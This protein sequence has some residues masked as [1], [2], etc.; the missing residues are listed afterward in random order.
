MINNL[1]ISTVS[2]AD[3][4]N[5]ALTD[6]S[7][8]QNLY[9]TAPEK[10][11]AVISHALAKEKGYSKSGSVLGLLTS[12]TNNIVSIKELQG[13]NYEWD[14][15][16]PTSRIRP[17]TERVDN[18]ER[19]GIAKSI[20]SLAFGDRCFS[21][22]D[23]I[24]ASTG[25]LLYVMREMQP[26]GT[27]WIAYCTLLTD[28]MTDYLPISCVEAG[29]PYSKEYSLVPELSERGGSFG[30]GGKATL[31]NGISR[32]RMSYTMS[33]DALN[34]NI[35]ISFTDDKGKQFK[36]WDKMLQFKALME[37]KRQE[38]YL[39][40]YG[41]YI[42]K[43]KQII[44]K[45]GRPISSGAG[46]R[47][48][49]APSNVMEHNGRI[50]YEALDSY[51]WELSKFGGSVGGDA[52]FVCL[53][54]RGFKKMLDEAIAKKYNNMIPNGL[55]VDKA[56]IITGSGRTMTFEGM[57]FDTIKFDCGITVSFKYFPL[58]DDMSTAR[59]FLTEPST[60]L[61]YDSF[62]AT[63]FNI[64][65]QSTIKRFYQKDA[66][67]CI[68][69]VEGSIDSTGKTSKSESNGKAT[70]LDGVE[71]HHLGTAGIA[72]LDP[73]SAGEIVYVPPIW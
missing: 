45:N 30:I 23:V 67:H 22:T 50:S 72:L 49:I 27:N 33:R 68:W 8:I 44:A 5:L 66:D 3:L 21:E 34:Q 25:Q 39:L 6:A 63:C 36:V 64:G 52:S 38:D 58:Y 32:L 53:H 57:G 54:G 11:D 12:G 59:N 73:H 42:G 16:L 20:I 24:V 71:I 26:V 29:A 28:K 65:G 9:A 46:L 56:N 62:R 2:N 35:V 55:F 10:I 18:S 43:D 48:Q 70:G 14:V 19:P 17:T 41:P 13:M 60:G 1:Q 7:M 51:F 4:N 37:F 47:D 61:P 40:M 31:R 69:S 15:H